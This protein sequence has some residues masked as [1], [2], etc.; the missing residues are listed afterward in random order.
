MMLHDKLRAA[1]VGFE[2]KRYLTVISPEHGT[3]PSKVAT[4]FD[5]CDANK[6]LINISNARRVKLRRRSCR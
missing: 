4:D 6:T 2:S 3:L 1:Q 5:A